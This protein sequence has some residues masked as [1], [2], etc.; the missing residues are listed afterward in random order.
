MAPGCSASPDLLVGCG[1]EMACSTCFAAGS[2]CGWC[3]RLGACSSRANCSNEFTQTCPEISLPYSQSSVATGGAT[4]VV[5]SNVGLVSTGNYFC[6]FATNLI[7]ANRTS[8]TTVQCI[9]PTSPNNTDG[10]VPLKLV[11]GPSNIDFALPVPFE[12]Y[13]SSRLLLLSGL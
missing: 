7:P 2:E 9:A 8:P 1:S 12:F 4:V 5:Q 3:L 11:Y 13:G 10:F 6:Q